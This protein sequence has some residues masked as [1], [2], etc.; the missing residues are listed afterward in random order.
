[1]IY[2]IVERVMRPLS[3]K[4][5]RRPQSD[6]GMARHFIYSSSSHHQGTSSHQHEDDDDDNVETSRASTPSPT[7]YLNSLNLLNYQN[8]Q[9]PSS[10]EQTDE[11]LFERQTTLLNQTQHVTPPNWVT[12]D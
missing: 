4:Q 5:T 8:Y 9:M 7:T 11:T 2:D 3:L 12:A 10:S 6:R 1:G